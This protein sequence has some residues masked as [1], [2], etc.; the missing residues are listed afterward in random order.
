MGTI[1]G[2]VGG[3]TGKV[4]GMVFYY[5][6]G[7]YVA[8]EYI[9]SPSN[10]KSSR[11][12]E[13]RLKLALAGRLSK[14]VPYEALEGFGGSRP[15]RRSRF[16]SG[17]MAGASVSGGSA[18]IDDGLLSFSDG[19]LPL[20]CSH[21]VRADSSTAYTRSLDI[22]SSL[23]EGVEYPSGYGER[24]VVLF[25]DGYGSQY[26]Y[27]LTGLLN[28]PTVVGTPVVTNVLLKVAEG[29]GAYSALVYVYPFA[30]SDELRGGRFRVSFLGSGD[31]TV[32]VDLDTGEEFGRPDVFGKS[33]FIANVALDA[34]S[35]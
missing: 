34:P 27:C 16:L 14:V 12:V 23:V 13:Q 22:V 2:V 20:L 31:G 21:T 10:P 1:N 3:I 11:Q 4:G 7:K 19:A 6:N 28:A 8:R 17:V 26:D 9:A 15:D 30:V 18:L 32:L 33:Q 35:A 29:S 5:R 24:Y 25:L